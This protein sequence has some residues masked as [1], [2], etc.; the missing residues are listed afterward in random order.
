MALTIATVP[1]IFIGAAFAPITSV[2]THIRH[3]GGPAYKCMIPE[4]QCK[5][6]TLVMIE[7]HLSF[8]ETGVV[9]QTQHFILLFLR[10]MQY[11]ETYDLITM[12][13]I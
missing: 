2:N 6:P 3:K 8:S 11:V 1:A 10:V 4:K 5:E 9:V 13:F 7:V 12:I